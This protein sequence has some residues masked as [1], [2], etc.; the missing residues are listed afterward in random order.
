MPSS[1][2]RA[3]C[4]LIAASGLLT[5]PARSVAADPAATNRV[6]TPPC[7]PVITAPGATATSDCQLNG[8]ANIRSWGEAANADGLLRGLSGAEVRFEAVQRTASTDSRWL[9]ALVWLG[10]AVPAQVVFEGQLR[11]RFSVDI[12]RGSISP[13]GVE[14]GQVMAELQ[15]RAGAAPAVTAAATRARDSTAGSG[16]WAEPVWQPL[17]LTL[18][19]TPAAPG[20]TLAY[21]Q[22]LI[23][24]ATATNDW[25]RQGGGT[26]DAQAD[27]RDGSGLVAVR[28]LDADG[29]ELGDRVHWA[30]AHGVSPVPEPAA[31]ALMLAGGLLLAARARRRR[32]GVSARWPSAR[33]RRP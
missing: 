30:W 21:E 31:P 27:F 29:A 20:A 8:N 15:L 1:L 24:R 18:A 19:W 2:Q 26:V 23:T 12:A 16:L 17:T 33:C 32:G 4:A 10:G 28:W 25:F 11:G 6:D 3:A 14:Q 22:R 13:P 9:D 5:L 7:A